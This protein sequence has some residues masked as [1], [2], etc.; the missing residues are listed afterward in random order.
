MADAPLPPCPIR[1][2]VR[3]ESDPDAAPIHDRSGEY[4]DRSFRDWI[5]NTTWWALRNGKSVHTYPV[6]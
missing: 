3:E 5:I 6:L 2:V 1:F 4:N